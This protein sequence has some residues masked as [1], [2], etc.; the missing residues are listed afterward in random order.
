[1]G[2]PDECNYAKQAA[3]KKTLDK[4]MLPE[5]L[6]KLERLAKSIDAAPPS[7]KKLEKS[8]GILLLLLSLQK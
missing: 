3:L 5:N 6:V 8:K 1:M 2:Q 7:K 4:T